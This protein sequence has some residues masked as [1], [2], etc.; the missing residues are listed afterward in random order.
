[1]KNSQKGVAHSFTPREDLL[2]GKTAPISMMTTLDLDAS[3]K[4]MD[5]TPTVFLVACVASEPWKF[6]I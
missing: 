1:M 4:S 5:R 3:T 2:L 6:L